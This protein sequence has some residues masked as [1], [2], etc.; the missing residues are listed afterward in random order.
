MYA[1]NTF[2]PSENK[3]FEVFGLKIRPDA[4]EMN[5]L[6]AIKQN[7]LEKSRHCSALL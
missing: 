1:D 6:F 5:G 4:W 3:D 7:P 2:P